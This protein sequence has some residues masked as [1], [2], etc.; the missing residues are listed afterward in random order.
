MNF[1]TVAPLNDI[2]DIIDIFLWIES[3]ISDI[4]KSVSVAHEILNNKIKNFKAE[5][6][7]DI[8]RQ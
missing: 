4:N 7:T 5:I 8:M 2:L 1:S 6:V 3:W